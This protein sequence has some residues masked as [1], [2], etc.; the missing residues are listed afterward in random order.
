MVSTR[1]PDPPADPQ[2]V[3]V[4]PDSDLVVAFNPMVGS[5]AEPRNFTSDAISFLASSVE[6]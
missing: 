2:H 5:I 4:F 6:G 3:A 1:G